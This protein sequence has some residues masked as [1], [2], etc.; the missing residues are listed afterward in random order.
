MN[1]SIVKKN[2]GNL[3]RKYRSMLGLSQAA[4][5]ENCG[6]DRNYVSLIERGGVAITIPT[7]LKL[8]SA[9]SVDPG[10]LVSELFDVGEYLN[11]K[12]FYSEF[13]KGY[14]NKSMGV[15][16]SDAYLGFVRAKFPSGGARILD[17]GCGFG[18]CA[19]QLVDRGYEVVGFDFCDELLSLGRDFVP[20]VKF[21]NQDI[22]KI[23]KTY[24]TFDIVLAMFSLNH[25]RG[26][27]L[28]GVFLNIRDVIRKGGMFYFVVA[29]GRDKKEDEVSPTV[30]E[31]GVYMNNID[32]DD[33]VYL[34]ENAGFQI[35]NYSEFMESEL[36]FMFSEKGF[37][38]L[39]FLCGI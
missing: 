6:L 5:G 15:P 23:N 26:V 17:L 30:F 29:V 37:Y 28:K 27:D 18:R 14:F 33:W 11:V 25:I 16:Y 12:M 9:L 32:K 38:D 8:A 24:G 39:S 35:L 36:S 20:D 1:D 22:R 13:A 7:L 2:F 21:Y 34:I 3:V 4:L 31:K 10:V 19:R